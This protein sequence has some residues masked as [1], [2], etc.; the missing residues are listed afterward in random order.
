MVKI[1]P[2][3]PPYRG[4]A[5]FHGGAQADPIRI[6]I[7]GTVSPTVEGGAEAIAR[8]FRV[9]VT[10]ASSAHYV[11][12]PGAV[13]Q[14]VYDHVEAY[15]A[16]PNDRSIGIE[17]C[18]PVDGPAAR[19]NDEA[20]VRM[21]RRAAHLTARLTL[22]YGVRA[23]KVGPDELR[24]SGRGICGHIDVSNAWHQTTHTDPGPAFPWPRFMRLVRYYRGLILARHVVTFGRT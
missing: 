23:R 5:K 8:Y 12:D 20:H 10:R 9:T 11:V 16:P 2:P 21:L 15:H 6:V 13:R 3:N 1:K 24:R 22:A 19:W 18:D 17:L 4:P 14:V 7:H